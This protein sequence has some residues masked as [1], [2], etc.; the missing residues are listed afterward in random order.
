MPERPVA[1]D[2]VNDG[3]LA[4]EEHLPAHGEDDSNEVHREFRFANLHPRDWF[5]TFDDPLSL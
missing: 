4:A 3:I 5:I 2:F 1:E